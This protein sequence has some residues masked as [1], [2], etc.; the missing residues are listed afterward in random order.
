MNAIELTRRLH[1]E[2]ERS[3]EI[4]RTRPDLKEK[5]EDFHEGFE[6]GIWES[7]EALRQTLIYNYMV[8]TDPDILAGNKKCRTRRKENKHD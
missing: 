5:S 6:T 1:Q 2:I 8:N 7:Y 4:Y 3:I